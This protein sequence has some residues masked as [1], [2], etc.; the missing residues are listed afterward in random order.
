[1]ITDFQCYNFKTDVEVEGPPDQTVCEYSS[2]VYQS[3]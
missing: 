1:M 3:S 2:N